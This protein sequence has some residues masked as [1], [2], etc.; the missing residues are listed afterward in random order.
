MVTSPADDHERTQGMKDLEGPREAIHPLDGLLEP[1]AK[2][3]GVDVSVAISLKRIADALDWQKDNT[4][5]NPRDE[6]GRAL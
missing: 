2:S 1:G 5:M 4:P 6:Y 3:F